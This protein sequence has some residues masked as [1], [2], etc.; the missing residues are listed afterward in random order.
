MDE[1]QLKALR[2]EVEKISKGKSPGPFGIL[3]LATLASGITSYGSKYVDPVN[4]RPDPYTGAQGLSETQARQAADK[5]IWRELKH[6]RARD[7]EL[8]ERLKENYAECKQGLEW[9]KQQIWKGY[10]QRKGLDP[11]GHDHGG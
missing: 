11:S 3:I 8:K 5:E 1:E 4:H 6:I 7:D 10:R 9:C 2:E